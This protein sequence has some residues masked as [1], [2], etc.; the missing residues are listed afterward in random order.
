MAEFFG[1]LERLA[2]DLYPYRWPILVGV[3]AVLAAIATYGYRREWHIAA[4]KRRGVAIIVGTPLL[5]LAGFLAW[6]LG[7]P[8]FVD[9]TV[10][11]EFP[12]AFAAVVP[13]DMEREDIEKTMASLAK[14]D[15]GP[16]KEAMPEKM[17]AGSETKGAGSSEGQSAEGGEAVKLKEGDFRDQDSFHKGSGKAAIY[18]APDGSHLVRL[19]DFKVTNGPD[20]HVL[21]SAHVDPMDR[22]E[23]KDDG[24]HD[25][26]KLKGNIGSQ[27]YPVPEGVD[28][29]AQMSVVIYC[30]PFFVIFSVAPLRDAS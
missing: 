20:L 27:N 28:V 18:R 13:P 22:N 5:A 25:L 3:L 14:M 9:K 29:A 7:S 17:G 12:F 6:D 16:I 26:G 24:F 11:E 23:L 1:D 19:D 2:A 15:D 30:K 4:W 10:E 8:L 21:L